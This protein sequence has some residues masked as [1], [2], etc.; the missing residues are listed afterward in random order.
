MERVEEQ[1][2]L[3]RAVAGEREV[4]LAA[5]GRTVV[6]AVDAYREVVRCPG[7]PGWFLGLMPGRGYEL[8]GVVDLGALLRVLSPEGGGERRGAPRGLSKTGARRRIVLVRREDECLGLA[9]DVGL[10]WTRDG[11]QGDV[12]SLDSIWCQVADSLAGL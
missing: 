6:Y 10:G 7:M 1:G 12:W 3:Y 2:W 9:L 8:A 4:Y 11:V 5:D